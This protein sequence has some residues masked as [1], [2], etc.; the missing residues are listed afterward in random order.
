MSSAGVGIGALR[1]KPC[2]V[3]ISIFSFEIK[4]VYRFIIYKH[5]IEKYSTLVNHLWYFITGCK[6]SNMYTFYFE[7]KKKKK[8]KTLV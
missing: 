3:I 1:V 8:K 2:I 5:V 6:Y 4:L 7:K